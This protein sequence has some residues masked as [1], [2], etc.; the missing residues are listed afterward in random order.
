MK[1]W[2]YRHG[3]LVPVVAQLM[4]DEDEECSQGSLRGIVVLDPPTRDIDCIRGH[5]LFTIEAVTL[6]SGVKYWEMSA[7]PWAKSGWLRSSFF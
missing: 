6:Q 1:W 4:G 2:D 5:G 3:G 7:A